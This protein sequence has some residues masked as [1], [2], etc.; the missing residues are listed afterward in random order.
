M[1]KIIIIAIVIIALGASAFFLF[2]NKPKE[3]AEVSFYNYAIE[4]AFITNVRESQKLFKTSII[5][6]VNKEEMDEYLEENIYT[7]RD[8]ILTILRSLTDEDISGMDIQD[9]LRNEI[10]SAL[11]NALGIDNIASV[12]FSDFVMQ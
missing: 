1:K 6:V 5:L 3:E 7:I 11:N 8:T 9:R 2:F 10:S 4:D 12:Y